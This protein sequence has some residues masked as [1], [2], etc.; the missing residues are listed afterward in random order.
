MTPESPRH[1]RAAPRRTGHRSPAARGRAAACRWSSPVLAAG[2]WRR[3][4][5]CCWW[6]S[7]A[8]RTRCGRRR[9]GSRVRTS[10]TTPASSAA[11]SRRAIRRPAERPDLARN[12]QQRDRCD[13]RRRPE[14]GAGVAR[15]LRVRPL[16]LPGQ[17][18]LPLALL[19]SQMVPAF[20]LLVPYYIVLRNSAS[21]T[22]C[23]ASSSR[24]RHHPA[25]HG[26]AAACLLPGHPGRPR[27]RRPDRRLRP[28]ATFCRVVLPLARPGL[29]A[30]G[31]FA[32][33]V[34]L[35]RFPLRRRAQHPDRPC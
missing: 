11:R 31:L 24:S 35:E 14:R 13:A 3:S 34:A 28:A 5:S 29:I 4:T 17:R 6:P 21:R 23:T 8:R 15:R 1:R 30:V 27:T 10:A 32:F 26:L 2:C 7:R 25:V 9:S 19:G 33:M 22:R 20:A 18:S 16:P 12:R